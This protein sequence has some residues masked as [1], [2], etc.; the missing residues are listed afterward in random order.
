MFVAL[1]WTMQTVKVNKIMKF[2]GKLIEHKNITQN[3]KAK[4]EKNVRCF[5]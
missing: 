3:E 4:S 5:Q 1:F 2:V